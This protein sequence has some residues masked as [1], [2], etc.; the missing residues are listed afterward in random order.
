MDLKSEIMRRVEAL[1]V[2]RQRQ[3]L[4]YVEGLE[5]ACPR[6]ENGAALVSSLTAVLDEVSAAEMTQAIESACEGVDPREW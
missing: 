2:E 1:P 6:G 3:F 5:R 4:V